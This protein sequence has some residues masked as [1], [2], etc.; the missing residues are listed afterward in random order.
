[1]RIITASDYSPL[2][3]RNNAN[4]TDIFRVNQSGDISV[5]K[6]VSYTW[7]TSQGAANTIL[8]NNGSGGLTWSAA[9]GGDGKTLKM[10]V[11]TSSGTW[12][13]PAG[14]DTV[15]VTIYGGGGGGA[16]GGKSGG[17]GGGNGGGGGGGGYCYIRW[18]FGVTSSVSVTVGSGGAGGAYAGVNGVSGSKG[19]SSSFGSLTVNG[20]TGGVGTKSEYYG[21][22]GAGGALGGG[23]GGPDVPRSYTDN[24][25]NLISNLNG[26]PGGCV[27]PFFSFSGGGGSGGGGS[28]IYA[29]GGGGGGG[30]GYSGN[31]GNGGYGDNTGSAGTAGTGYGSGGGGAGGNGPGASGGGGT[32]GIVIVE[33]WQ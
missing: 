28:N 19:G 10:Q 3:I 33:W 11:F 12:T 30:C 23:N 21:I 27:F 9:A 1:M 2:N 14:V 6:S 31:G 13:Q 25:N 15:L 8:T 7:P 26:K 29:A 17:S 20:G 4:S 5:L 24:N 22:G 18:L 32:P 16:S